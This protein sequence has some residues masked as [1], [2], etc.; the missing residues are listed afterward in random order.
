VVFVG[1]NIQDREASA[2]ECLMEFGIRYPNGIDTG[3]RISLVTP[4]A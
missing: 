4:A 2:R 3:D 1:A